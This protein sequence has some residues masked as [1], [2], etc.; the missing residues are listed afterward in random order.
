MNTLRHTALAG[1]LLL[2]AGGAFAG[3]NVSYAQPEQFSDVPFAP[4][5]RERVLKEL[6]RHFAKM[7][8]TLPAGQDLNVT[9]TDLDLAGYTWPS[10][11]TGTDLRIVKGGADWPHITIKYS[12]TQDGQVLRQGEEHLNN[13]NYLGR[14]NRYG[15]SDELRYEKQMLDDWFKE[16]IVTAR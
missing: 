4:W 9:V 1:M 10:M 12:V 15:R 2:A 8:A 5:E 16:R 7:G 6:T 13:M 3:V 14:I 11:H